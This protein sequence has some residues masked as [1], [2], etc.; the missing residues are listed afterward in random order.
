MEEAAISRKKKKRGGREEVETEGIRQG[1]FALKLQ[2]D[3]TPSP[4][5]PGRL[6]FKKGL[7]L[8][9]G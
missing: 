4:A 1:L 2:C 5:L 9:L 8:G 7:R 6:S 3:D